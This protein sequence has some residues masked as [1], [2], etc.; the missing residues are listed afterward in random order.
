MERRFNGSLKRLVQ[1]M[2]SFI[3]CNLKMKKVIT[4]SN[5]FFEKLYSFSKIFYRYEI[6]KSLNPIKESDLEKHMYLTGKT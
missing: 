4:I 5:Y 2:F 1:R 3:S 6:M